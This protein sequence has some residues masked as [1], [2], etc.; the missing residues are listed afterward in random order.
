MGQERAAYEA[1]FRA[2]A[3]AGWWRGFT[4]LLRRLARVET[5]DQARALLREVEG[6]VRKGK[7]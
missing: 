1:G 5:Q 4:Y 2:G 3:R 6:L 7:G